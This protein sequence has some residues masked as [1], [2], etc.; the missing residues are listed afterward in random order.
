MH[1]VDPAPVEVTGSVR[2]SPSCL[3]ATSHSMRSGKPSTSLASIWTETARLRS[4]IP[5]IEPITDVD[6]GV[7]P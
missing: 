7:K 5:P 3:R 1:E 6:K 4:A 2:K